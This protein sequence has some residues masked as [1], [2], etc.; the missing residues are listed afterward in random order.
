[1]KKIDEI[2]ENYIGISRTELLFH[3]RST[4][5]MLLS[6]FSALTGSE[7][8]ALSVIMAFAAASVSSDG[9]FSAGEVE[10]AAELLHLSNEQTVSLLVKASHPKR[11]EAAHNLFD[12]CEGEV[13]M[14]ILNLCLCFIACDGTIQPREST[15]IK[16]LV[17]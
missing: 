15:F 10:F 6:H 13:Q 7:Y 3:A 12:A 2:Y 16:S 9:T 8:D 17:A 14:M 5:E 1:M 4:V 11:T